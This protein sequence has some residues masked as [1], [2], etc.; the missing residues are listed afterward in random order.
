MIT[1]LLRRKIEDNTEIRVYIT[2]AAQREPPIKPLQLT[3]I[4]LRNP[5]RRESNEHFLPFKYISNRQW[6]LFRYILMQETRFKPL[7]LKNVRALNLQTFNDLARLPWNF[8]LSTIYARQKRHSNLFFTNRFFYC[9][10]AK[11]K[12]YTFKKRRNK[13]LHL[14]KES[15]K[16][17]KKVL[18]RKE[19]S[20]SGILQR[21]NIFRIREASDY[22]FTMFY[23]AFSCSLVLQQF[24]PFNSEA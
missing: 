8:A 24:W 22:E 13:I 11:Y 3:K 2:G 23:E 10:H 6:L 15:I 16:S 21:R 14:N 12:I 20:F 4:L 17:G 9:K 1:Y 7:E 5:L 18:W 19:I